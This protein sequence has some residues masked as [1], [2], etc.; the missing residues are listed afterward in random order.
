MSNLLEYNVYLTPNQKEKL[1]TCFRNKTDCTLRI[2]PKN[3][4]NKFKLTA[5]QI[6]K[7]KTARAKNKSCDIKLSKLNSNRVE[8]FYHFYYH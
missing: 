4:N 8:D 2:E 6:Q 5:T 1:K 3:G 7:L